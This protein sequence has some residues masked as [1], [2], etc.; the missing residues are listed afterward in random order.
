MEQGPRHREARGPWPTHFF[1]KN[2]EVC[3]KHNLNPKTDVTLAWPPYFQSQCADP[4]KTGLALVAEI[5]SP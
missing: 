3:R 2:I 4:V 1:Q 5:A